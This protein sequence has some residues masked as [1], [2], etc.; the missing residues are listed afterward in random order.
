MADQE[1]SDKTRNEWQNIPYIGN[2]EMS[3]KTRNEWQKK[4][5]S[6]KDLST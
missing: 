2:Q 6:Y 4:G 5:T 3:D 1:M